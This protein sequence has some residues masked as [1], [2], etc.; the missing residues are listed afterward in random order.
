MKQGADTAILQVRELFAALDE[1][2]KRLVSLAVHL[3]IGAE[4]HRNFSDY[5]SL[6]HKDRTGPL[7]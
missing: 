1:A 3:S 6:G 4:T 5:L 2:A 7:L